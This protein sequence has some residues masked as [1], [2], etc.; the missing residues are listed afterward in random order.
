MREMK[1]VRKTFD[2][3]LQALKQTLLRMTDLAGR[4]L[5]D[6]MIALR[7]QN[8]LLAQV[9]ID[10]D[11]EIN[12]MDEEINNRV[13]QLIA[14]QQPVATDLRRII[15]ALKIS[16]DVERIGDLAVNIA[17][18]TI[19]I[20][21]EPLIKPIVDIPK[22]AAIVQEMLRHAFEAYD[23]ENPKLALELA[24]VDDR[25]DRMYGEQ[26]RELM[27]LM[28]VTPRRIN[29]ITQLAFICRDLERVGDHTTNMAESILYLTKGEHYHLN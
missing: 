18:C 2:Q 17:K 19:R 20:G 8:Q 7:E 9:V 13:I 16:T 12:R 4:A 1:S 27:Q 15:T 28:T 3:E 5:D 21:T 14:H 25:V 11:G 23:L 24:E 26:I 22:M 29:Q 6:S 10:G